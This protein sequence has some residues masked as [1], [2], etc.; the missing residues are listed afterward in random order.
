MAGEK[1]VYDWLKKELGDPIE[2]AAKA[3]LGI[4]GK[5]GKIDWPGVASK[6]PAGTEFYA[7]SGVTGD[8]IP[9]R[10][11]FGREG[12][13]SDDPGI[14]LPDSRIEWNFEGLMGT[15]A[16]I[17]PE[18][19]PIFA[20]ANGGGEVVPSPGSD[21]ESWAWASKY[22]Q[23]QRQVSQAKAIKQPSRTVEGL[24]IEDM[25]LPAAGIGLAW[26]LFS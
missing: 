5:G 4:F 11:G 14:K 6:F 1:Q 9:V 22:L 21:L 19:P 18:G 20:V 12:G 17:V 10:Y 26:W 13:R 24:A 8:W 16:A 15:Y 25:A 3:L 23:V 2:E 7:R